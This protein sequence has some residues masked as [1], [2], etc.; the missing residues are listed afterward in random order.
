ML[1]QLEVFYF[2]P[3]WVDSITLLGFVLCSLHN[4]IASLPPPA[5]AQSPGT[6]ELA[7]STTSPRRTPLAG[8]VSQISIVIDR[9][10]RVDFHPHLEEREVEGKSP[11]SALETLG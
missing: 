4:T 8:S 2:I 6:T 10:V 5:S 11:E 1:L 3:S 7:Q 9:A